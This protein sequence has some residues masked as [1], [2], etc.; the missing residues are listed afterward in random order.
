MSIITPFHPSYP[1]LYNWG[2][3]VQLLLASPLNTDAFV[4]FLDLLKHH[5]LDSSDKN[6]LIRWIFLY[7]PRHEDRLHLLRL[8]IPA[9]QVNNIAIELSSSISERLYTLSPDEMRS[10]LEVL[11][12]MGIRISSW[13]VY[14]SLFS[15]YV[16]V[17]ISQR[18]IPVNL[19]DY[20]FPLAGDEI[21]RHLHHFEQKYSRSASLNPSIIE[22]YLRCLTYI[23]DPIEHRRDLFLTL[24]NTYR[25]NVIILFEKLTYRQLDPAMRELLQQSDLT[26]TLTSYLKYASIG[27]YSLFYQTLH[28]KN[29][30]FV[31]RIGTEEQYFRDWRD[32]LPNRFGHN[33]PD[34][35]EDLRSVH[36]GEVLRLRFLSSDAL[37]IGETILQVKEIAL[38]G[39]R[40]TAIKTPHVYLSNGF[41]IVTDATKTPQWLQTILSIN[42]VPYYWKRSK[43]HTRLQQQVEYVR[44]FRHEAS[45]VDRCI[46]MVRRRYREKHLQ[47]RI[48]Q[49]TI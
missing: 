34:I 39:I 33:A 48:P 35:I 9:Y 45:L 20:L 40:G 16:D 13:P 3:Q 2:H 11:V 42:T 27:I 17:M 12:S 32:G 31:L 6:D 28:E 4:K 15:I 19:V 30:Q 23:D 10:Y 24:L 47:G 29:L 38:K 1:S 25:P 46:L 41:V 37:I 22:L 7:I 5:P 43:M 8:S 44:L 18:T 26:I 21:V 49:R 14:P 36:K